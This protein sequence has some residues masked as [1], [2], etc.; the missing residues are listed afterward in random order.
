[1]SNSITIALLCN[2]KMA[3][4]ALQSMYDAGVLCA[5]ATTNKDPEV[6]A[7]FRSKATEYGIPFT[8]I[9][10]R[11]Y[12]QQLAQW[13][14]ATKPELVFVMT[15]PWRLPADVLAIPP[16]G[17]Y[18]FHYGLLPQMRGADPIFESIRQGLP[19]AGV[20]VHIMNESFDTGPIVMQEQVPLMPHY[21]YGML[22]S[23]LAFT[24]SKMCAQLVQNFQKSESLT[25]TVQD[26]TNA[27]YWPRISEQELWIRWEEMNAEQISALVRS[28]NPIAK[29]VPTMIN[30]WK[31]GVC[32]VSDVNLQGD[33]SAILPGTILAIDAQNG[34]IVCCKDGKALKLD[35]VYMAEGT[36]PGYKLSYF[37]IMQGMIFS[38]PNLNY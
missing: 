32:D 16:S 34:L 10:Y 1:M 17:F 7:A 8:T 35:V 14:N 19:T 5:V 30:N 24:G 21:T 9:T 38:T 12:A 13:L 33:A 29:G 4:P 6:V 26:E 20:T 37:G 31:I 15:F 36:L 28:C 11:N 3:M 2:N 18:N 25:I 27:A 22:S 23:Q